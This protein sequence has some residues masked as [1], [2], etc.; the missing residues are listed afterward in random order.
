VTVAKPKPMPEALLAAVATRFRALAEPTRLRIL[1][2]LLA[3]ERSVNEITAA[4]GQ[5][6]ANTSKHLSTLRATGFL[7]RRK[8]GSTVLYS[9]ADPWVHELCDLMCERVSAELRAGARAAAGR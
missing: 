5:S 9:I 4:I 2:H 1:Q 7:V 6:Q 8:E 3:G